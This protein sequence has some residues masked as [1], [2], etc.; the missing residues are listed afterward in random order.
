MAIRKSSRLGIP[1]GNTAGR[2][3][4]ASTGQPYFNG[5]LS[6]LELYT[7]IGWQN[8]VQETPG[9]S[10]ISGNYS[11]SANSGTITITGT[12]FASGCYATAIGSNGVQIDATSTTFNSLVQ[13]TA[14]FNGLSSDYEP[15]GIKVTNPSNLFGIIPDALYI[16]NTPVW[17]TAAGSLGTFNEQV[18][19]SVSAIATDSDSTIA[20]S[21]ES[22]SSLPSGIILNSS[23]GLISGTLPDISV[24]TTYTFTINAS[25]GVN[26]AISRTFS[27]TSIPYSIV[28]G[29]TLT[30]D[31]TYYYRTFTTNGTLL[32]S[33]KALTCDILMI[34]GAA[35][36]G[37]H[38]GG[39]GGAGGIIHYN[40][41]SLSTGSYSIAIGNGGTG[42]QDA[43]DSTNGQGRDTTFTGLESALGGGRGGVSG[44]NGFSGGSGG[45]AA[46]TNGGAPTAGSATQ[47]SGTGYTGYGNSGGLGS[48]GNE[49]SEGGGGG[50]SGSIGNNATTSNAGTGGDGTN[51]FSSWLSAISS[52]MPTAW[53]NATSA[54]RIAAGGGGGAD[55]RAGG[56][57]A[58]GGVGGGGNGV[59]GNGTTGGAG[60]TNTGSGGG[61]GSGGAGGALTF[62]GAGGS[63]ICIVRYTKSSVGA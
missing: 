41:K 18:S 28:T 59:K 36:G 52:I 58:S 53:Q 40:S 10:S 50:G 30:S 25:D 19:V 38:L 7:S 55:Q 34:G 37:A 35:A 42:S 49:A 51:V 63:G 23:T 13:V 29:G 21:L 11:E 31:S 8:I 14:V 56:S 61:G 5:E 47:S 3:A 45:G 60:V 9:V 1:F 12:N 4:S 54:G 33:D 44:G 6:R 62:G 27:I 48:S 24:Q 16:N 2:P 26:T 57:A 20:Y 46:G 22:G 39:G 17:S 15:Y 32:I 43:G